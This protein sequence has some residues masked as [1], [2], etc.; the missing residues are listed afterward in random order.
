MDTNSF[1]V[2]FAILVAN[3]VCI[4]VQLIKIQTYVPMLSNS[5]TITLYCCIYTYVYIR[6]YILTNF[7]IVTNIRT[8]LTTYKK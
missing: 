2:F 7:A 4:I 3:S 8:Q 6:M 5:L 1:T